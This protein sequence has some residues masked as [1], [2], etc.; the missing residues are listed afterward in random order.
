MQVIY[1]NVI[2]LIQ[3]KYSDSSL[4]E[5]LDFLI[6]DKS[7]AHVDIS[8]CVPSDHWF[9]TQRNVKKY[10]NRTSEAGEPSSNFPS[11][12][13]GKSWQTITSSET[14]QWV[15]DTFMTDV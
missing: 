14:R 15:R 6:D 11:Q 2:V 10:L 5:F 1:S 12:E 7:G 13:N 8:Y 4:Y 3:Q 9:S